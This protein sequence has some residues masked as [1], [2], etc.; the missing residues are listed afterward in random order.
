M[1]VDEVTV[2]KQDIRDIQ[3]ELHL[4]SQGVTAGHPMGVVR[5]QSDGM[6]PVAPGIPGVE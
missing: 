4:L 3:T 1:L 6:L 5:P 2:V